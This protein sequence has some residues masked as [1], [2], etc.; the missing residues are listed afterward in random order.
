MYETDGILNP[1]SQWTMLPRGLSTRTD[2]NGPIPKE[3]GK[4]H[5]TLNKKVPSLDKNEGQSALMLGARVHVVANLR[6]IFKRTGERGE[7]RLYYGADVIKY[8]FGLR[9]E[10]CRGK[11]IKYK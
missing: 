10:M 4:F 2:T 9:N 1:V 7:F 6:M 3:I 5:A 11:Q 8:P